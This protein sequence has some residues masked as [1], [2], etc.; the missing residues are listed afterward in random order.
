MAQRS[1][2][3]KFTTLT[4]ATPT[5]TWHYTACF[6]AASLFK[7]THVLH[8]SQG[9]QVLYQRSIFTRIGPIM[10]NSGKSWLTPARGIAAVLILVTVGLAGYASYFGPGNLYPKPVRALLREGGMAYLR[11]ENK[12]DLPKAIECY[13]KALAILDELGASDPKH[14]PGVSH[15]TGLVARI[16]SVYSEMGD[17]DN[18]IRAYKDVLQRILGSQELDDPKVLVRQLLDKN[19]PAERRAN[20]LRALGCANKLAETYETRAA[21]WKRRSILL[22]DPAV[23]AASAD[24]KEA[25]HWYHWC[26]QLV[27]LTYQN[28]FNHLQLEKELPP[29]NIPSFDPSTLP[30]YFSIDIVT[31]LFYNAATY[32]ASNAQF[33]LAVPLLQR[34]LDLLQPGTC[35]GKETD[36]C[37]SAILMSHLANAA[38]MTSDLSGAEKRTIDGLALAKKFP[39]NNDC[40]SSFVALTYDLGAVYE[41]AGRS[42][43]ARVQY[44]QALEV[45]KSIRDEGAERLAIEALERVPQ[46]SNAEAETETETEAE[47]K[48]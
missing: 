12:Q 21:R 39:K 42:N 31:S 26:L 17:L 20:I 45:A 13:T 46:Q 22:A 14:A 32:F 18:A 47:T 9:T 41:A 28:H 38:V 34:A 3:R 23:A 37:R 36:V 4:T 8:I 43:S 35:N 5:Q 25:G 29:T 16:A 7:N 10:H 48:A 44:R 11:P 15:V 33:Q 30:R 1:T 19:L 24:V 2:I 40:L 27:M 6:R